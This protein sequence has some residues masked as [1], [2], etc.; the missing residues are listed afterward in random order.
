MSK[1]VNDDD[2]FLFNDRFTSKL[3]KVKIG[4]VSAQ[5][6]SEPEK[7][8][9]RQRIED[10][11]KPQIEAGGLLRSSHGARAKA[12]CLFIHTEA[13]LSLSRGPR[14]KPGASSFTRKLLSLIENK[15]STDVKYPPPP[16]VCM[17]I[18]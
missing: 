6:E 14:R 4:T 16:R 8:E 2:V 12:W 18:R 17:S 1:E 3:L 10:D 11:R 7:R 15:H 9:T 5:R 13:S